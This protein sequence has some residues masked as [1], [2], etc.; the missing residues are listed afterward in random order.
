MNIIAITTFFKQARSFSGDR[1]VQSV[2]EHVAQAQALR[3]YALVLLGIASVASLLWVRSGWPEDGWMH[4]GV[5]WI[6]ILLIVLAIFGRC[7]CMLYLSGRKGAE[8]VA[9]GPYSISRNPLYVFSLLAVFGIGLQTGSIIAATALAMAAFLVFRWVIRKEEHLLRT[10]FGQA[11]DDYCARVPRFWPRW[12]LWQSPEQ[13]TTDLPG[14]WRTLRDAAPYFLAIPLFEGIELI[15]QL[16]WI[17]PR[18]YLF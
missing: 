6:G 14:L 3:R 17:H 15:Q 9:Q 10:A 1:N 16:G 13:I 7:A 4:E 2:W 8:L 12:R 18:L 5:E 11:F